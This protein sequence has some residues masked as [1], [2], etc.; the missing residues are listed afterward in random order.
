[1]GLIL[2]VESKFNIF[3]IRSS[4]WGSLL[5][6]VILLTNAF[7]ICR[8]QV[9][10][11]SHILALSR[12]GTLNTPTV[13]MTFLLFAKCFTMQFILNHTGHPNTNSSRI[14]PKL[15]MS[16]AYGDAIDIFTLSFNNCSGGEYSGVATFWF[17]EGC[18]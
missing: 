17:V 11:L 15:N 13:L 18:T 5:V 9:T 4:S 6:I 16:C 1:M 7:S 2:C 3:L 14:T 8:I 12:M 10:C